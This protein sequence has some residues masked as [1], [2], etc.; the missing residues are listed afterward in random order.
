MF[1]KLRGWLILTRG[2]N[3]PTVWSNLL[4]GWAICYVFAETIPPFF[5]LLGGLLGLWVGVSFTYVGGMILNDAFDAKWDRTHRPQRPIPAGLVSERAATVVGFLFL[6]LGI[7]FTS[8]SAVQGHGRVVLVLSLVLAGLV[9]VYNRWHKGVTWAPAVMGLCRALLPII[10]FFSGGGVIDD[11]SFHGFG[12]LRLLAHPFVLWALT[13][14]VTL[15]ARHEAGVGRPP[16]WAEW[17]M[18]ALPLPFIFLYPARAWTVIGCAVYWLW[19]W[20]SNRRNPLPGGVGRRVSDRLAA[21]P[22][23]DFIGHGLFVYFAGPLGNSGSSSQSVWLG[24]ASLFACLVPPVCFGLTLLLR[25]W[26]PQT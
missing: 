14:S 13:F 18:Y 19:I 26:I 9:L 11:P 12:L 7:F 20:F 5:F 4:V 6:L 1:A 23:M 10:G 15:V 3:L 22:M 2:S 17:L 24:F 8:V 25:R 16:R 21:F